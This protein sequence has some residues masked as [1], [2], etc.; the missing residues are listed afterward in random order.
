[1]TCEIAATVAL[2]SILACMFCLFQMQR[3]KGMSRWY[4]G[5]AQGIKDMEALTEASREGASAAELLKVRENL[6]QI[7]P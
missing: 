1:M 7:K 2:I 6:M 5:R 4:A 3:Y